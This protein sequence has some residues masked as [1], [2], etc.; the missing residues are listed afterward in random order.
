MTD[1]AATKHGPGRILIAVY[2]VFALAATAR[3]GVQIATKFGDAPIAYLL[4]AVAAVIYCAATF[5]LA[6]ATVVSRKVATAAIAIELAGVIAIGAFSYAVPDDF[7][8]ATVWSHFGQGYGFVP[9][10]LP[11]LGL[12]WLRRTR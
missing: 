4:S 3:A 10:V 7:P 2:G 1:P 9:L 6:K 8:D 12:L 11:V 5:A